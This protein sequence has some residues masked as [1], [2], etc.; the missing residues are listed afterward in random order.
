M[1]YSVLVEDGDGDGT[2][3]S[4]N[5]DGQVVAVDEE[6]LGDEGARLVACVQ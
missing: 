2:S 5:V 6:W 1:L 4:G 3:T